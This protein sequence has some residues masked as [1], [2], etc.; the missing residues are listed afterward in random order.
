MR[1]HI[2]ASLP[3]PGPAWG[4]VALCQR[5]GPPAIGRPPTEPKDGPGRGCG[6]AGPK[7]RCSP[8]HPTWNPQA[9]AQAL[10]NVEATRSCVSLPIPLS[11]LFL[12]SPF[13]VTFSFSDHGIIGLL[14]A[15]QIFDPF[16]VLSSPLPFNFQES[17][18]KC[19]METC[20]IFE[21][22]LILLL[23]IF[24]LGLWWALIIFH[25]I[26]CLSFNVSYLP[27]LDCKTFDGKDCLFLSLKPSAMLHTAPSIMGVTHLQGAAGGERE[28]EIDGKE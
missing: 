20:L 7:S 14:H 5:K 12:S 19:E 24:A 9:A 22:D 28:R 17:Q 27:L 13:P 1:T 18:K 21:T 8:G 11:D 6:E 2:P 25:H 16:L 10:G 4:M 15:R 23:Q 26:L 3:T